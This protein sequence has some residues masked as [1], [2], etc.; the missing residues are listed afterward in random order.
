[1]E[2]HEKISSFDY[3]IELYDNYWTAFDFQF[4][5]IIYKMPVW[6]KN[7]LWEDYYLPYCDILKETWDMGRDIYL[8][9]IRK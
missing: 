6:D 9:T 7:D 1:M 2:K 4:D 5:T 3:S 8:E